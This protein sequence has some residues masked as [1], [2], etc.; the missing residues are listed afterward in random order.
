MQYEH[1]IQK[2]YE[3]LNLDQAPDGPKYLD[4][5]WT[6]KGIRGVMNVP[7]SQ[8]DNDLLFYSDSYRLSPIE[9]VQLFIINNL[10]IILITIG[11]SIYLYLKVSTTFNKF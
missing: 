3:I 5:K 8:S 1:V 6:E 7:I 2:V 10:V 4:I 11:S 9:H